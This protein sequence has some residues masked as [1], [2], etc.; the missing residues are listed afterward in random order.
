MA[1][2]G[3]PAGYDRTHTWKDHAQNLLLLLPLVPSVLGVKKNQNHIMQDLSNVYLLITKT[4]DGTAFFVQLLVAAAVYYLESSDRF[5]LAYSKFRKGGGLPTR[6]GMLIIYGL[7]L[8]TAVVCYNAMF[9]PDSV[10]HIVLF[11]AFVAHFGKRIV[12]VLFVHRYSKPMGWGT[13]FVIGG[14]YSYFALSAHFQQNMMLS[15]FEGDTLP[16]FPLLFGGL[17]FLFSQA[18]N[19]YHHLLLRNLRKAGE[20]GYVV[21]QGGLF[22]YVTCPHYFFEILAWIGYAIMARHLNIWGIVFII[23]AYLAGR[24]RQTREWYLEKVPGY[25]EERKALVPFAF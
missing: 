7:P 24:A 21:P 19:L 10:Y 2:A 5:H 15:P 12:E 8:L 4:I 11:V 25:P 9:R 20:S 23:A 13:A 22:A 3:R 17:I 16:L 14:L 18:L 1:V 6:I